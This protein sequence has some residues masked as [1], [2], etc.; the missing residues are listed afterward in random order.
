MYNLKHDILSDAE[1]NDLL[2][3][4]KQGDET[5]LEKL[6][7]GH[8]RLVS[9]AARRYY[10]P[11]YDGEDFVQMGMI[12]LMKA[13]RDYDTKKKVKFSTYVVTKVNGEIST[14]LRDHSHTMRISRSVSVAMQKIHSKALMDN[15]IE[16]IATALDM[17]NKECIETALAIIHNPL[18]SMDKLLDGEKKDMV[19]ELEGD[20]NGEW[21]QVIEIEELLNRLDSRSKEIIKLKYWHSLVNK[22]IAPIFGV[23]NAQI[24]R[25]EIAALATLKKEIEKEKLVHS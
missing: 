20:V 10:H 4:A 12:A 1:T 13:I 2:L 11:G 22:E 23:S 8:V 15:T 21:L 16:E 25:L 9:H 3:Q 6:V 18:L 7:E 19:V 17:D 5:A 24:S 14:W